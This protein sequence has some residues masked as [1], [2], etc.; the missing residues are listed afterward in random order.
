MSSSENDRNKR[1]WRDA[2]RH[3]GCLWGCLSEPFVIATLVIGSLFGAYNFGRKA[4]RTR[5]QPGKQECDS[6]ERKDD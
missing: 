2:K 1:E 6:Q 4:E 5:R 3:A